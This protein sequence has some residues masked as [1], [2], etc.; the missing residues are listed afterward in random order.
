[1]NTLLFY[2]VVLAI[3]LLTFII[4]RGKKSGPLVLGYFASLS[5]IYVP[6][7]LSYTGAGAGAPGEI[8]AEAGFRVVLIGLCAYLVGAFLGQNLNFRSKRPTAMVALDGRVTAQFGLLLLG[9]GIFSYFFAIP[10]LSFIPSATSLASAAGSLILVGYWYYLFYAFRAGNS[11]RIVLGLAALPLLPISTMITGGFLGFG[12]FW[13][14]AIGA[15]AYV[16]S[17]QKLII[18]AALPFLIYAG[19][20]FGVAYFADRSVLREN[21]WQGKA[22]VGG[23]FNTVVGMISNLEPLDINRSDHVSMLLARLNESTLVGA[24]VDNY[25][26]G[27]VDLVHGATVPVWA[28]V[29]RVVWPNKPPVGGGG[30]L[31]TEFTGIPFALDT[32][33]GIGQTLEFFMNFGQP[34]VII[35]FLIWGFILA[36]FDLTMRT[37]LEDGRLGPI[38]VA[39]LCGAAM[40]QPNGNLLEIIV[41]VVASFIVAQIAL[42][43]LKAVG[44]LDRDGKPSA[45]AVKPETN[46]SVP[47]RRL[48]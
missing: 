33:V 15:F 26:S 22:D 42:G 12:T 4:G 11:R 43:V 45:S 40:L 9:V 8:L 21:V 39:G 1:M 35:G 13:L 17:R 28:F 16:L 47:V 30:E 36:R 27:F 7:I 14:I 37:G 29:P 3:V 23:S 18:A 34:G 46:R 25:N 41:T 44:A 10:I 48:R 20:S 38:L 2:W 24:G 32:S 5:I 19:L 6:G 31:V